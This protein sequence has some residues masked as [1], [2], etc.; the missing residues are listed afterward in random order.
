[1]KKIGDRVGAVQSAD[2][3]NFYLFGYGVYEGD[4]IPV[5]AAGQLAEMLREVGT[6]N[7][8]IRLDS[9]KVVYGCECWWGREE[10]VRQNIGDRTVHLVDI[11]EARA[12]CRR[13]EAGN[14]R[15]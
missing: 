9:G 14:G 11:D 3:G 4:F 1:M 6:E 2:T 13:G 12:Q 7:P 10:S 8:R 15:G 5:E